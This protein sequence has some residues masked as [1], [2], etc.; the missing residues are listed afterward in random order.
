VVDVPP[1]DLL[2]AT[3]QLDHLGRAHF[4]GAATTIPSRGLQTQTIQQFIQANPDYWAL[5]NCSFPDDP[6]NLLKAIREGTAIGVC[7]GSYM[8]ELAPELGTAAWRIEDPETQEGI[9]GTVQTTGVEEEVDS[10]R[11]ELQGV[12]TML[13]GLWVICQY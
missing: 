9:L 7:D 4:E 12:H 3:A 2:R 11:S 8:Q 1:C 6:S 10:Y 5:L 13:L